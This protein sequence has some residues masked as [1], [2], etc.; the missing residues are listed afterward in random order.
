VADAECDV[1]RLHPPEQVPVLIAYRGL[2]SVETRSGRPFQ[3]DLVTLFELR[4]AE[5]VATQI[6]FLRIL[7]GQRVVGVADVGDEVRAVGRRQFVEGDARALEVAQRHDVV[8]GA[9]DLLRVVEVVGIER[10]RLAQHTGADVVLPVVDDVQAAV[11]HRIVANLP[12]GEADRGIVSGQHVDFADPVDLVVLH[13]GFAAVVVA[14]E[15]LFDD[16]RQVAD[17]AADRV[18][19]IAV[20]DVVDREVVISPIAQVAGDAFAFG[21]ERRAVENPAG[22]DER[23][24]R[25]L[26]DDLLDEL[27]V[28]FVVDLSVPRGRALLGAVGDNG[29]FAPGGRVDV[30]TDARREES[31]RLHVGFEVLGRFQGER[32]IVDDR[33]LADL[34]FEAVPPVVLVGVG[35]IVDPNVEIRSQEALVGALPHVTVEF[36]SRDTLLFGDVPVVLDRD[37][38]YQ[39]A[40]FGQFAH[41]AARRAEDAQRRDGDGVQTAHRRLLVEESLLPQQFEIGTGDRYVVLAAI[42]VAR[43]DLRQIGQSVFR[44]QRGGLGRS[45]L[46]GPQFVDLGVG[47]VLVAVVVHYGVERKAVGQGRLLGRMADD[48]RRQGDHP[49]GQVQDAADV[50]GRVERGAEKADAQPVRF[51]GKRQ[52]LGGE[53]GIGGGVEKPFEVVVGGFGVAL[54]APLREAVDVGA[55]RHHAGGLGDHGLI[56]VARCQFGPHAGV[57]R[58]DETVQLHVAAGRSARGRMQ[59]VGEYLLVDRGGFVFS[60][61]T[62]IRNLFNHGRQLLLNRIFRVVRAGSLRSAAAGRRAGRG[63]KRRP[64]RCTLS[65]RAGAVPPFRKRRRPSGG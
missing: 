60:D 9:V 36:R 29:P 26:Q 37:L 49:F 55:D 4:R 34:A 63:A 56:E 35:L 22:A 38:L 20:G 31:V 44:Q 61:R 43:E 39:I 28:E 12:I 54:L 57:E 47:V 19:G 41:D 65:R 40:P 14:R 11:S 50:A 10:N 48:D 18:V 32:R 7:R 30:V 62:M 13:D 16:H 5:D 53:Q 3:V 15:V 25:I 42:A 51:G 52:I 2:Q 1:E 6:A 23:G 33:F 8:V 46:F 21:V 24:S 27:V 45:L 64:W 59:D 17:A 58:H